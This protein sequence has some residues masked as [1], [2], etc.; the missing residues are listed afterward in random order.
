M[1]VLVFMV[2][3]QN[4]HILHGAC[5]FCPVPYNCHT[6]TQD[7]FYCGC[8]KFNSSQEQSA[9]SFLRKLCWAFFT[10]RDIFKAAM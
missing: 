2:L 7:A 4:A 3:F 10:R 1:R 5:P 8:I 9:A 6:G